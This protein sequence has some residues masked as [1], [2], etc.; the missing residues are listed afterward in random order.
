MAYNYDQLYETTPQALGNPTAEFVT[1]FQGHAERTFCVLDIGCGQGRDALF[2]ARLGHSV[3]GVDLSPHGI[4]EMVETAWREGL[5]VQGIVSDITTY[6]AEGKFNVLV[7]DRTLHMFD[8]NEQLE[9]LAKLLGAVDAGGWLLIADEISNIPDLKDVIAKDDGKWVTTL[10]Q[11]GTLF[12]KRGC[13]STSFV[14]PTTLRWPIDSSTPLSCAAAQI[15]SS[16]LFC[17]TSEGFS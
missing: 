5:N 9:T 10:D 13:R 11:N 4:A 15:I 17:E 1:F 2:I 12:A 6:A 3:V 14:W 7:I 8:E 16:C